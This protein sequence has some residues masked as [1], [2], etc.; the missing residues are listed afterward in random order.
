MK[1]NVLIAIML[2]SLTMLARYAYCQDLF[3]NS[4]LAGDLISKYKQLSA[5][6]LLDTANYYFDRN[7]TDTALVCYSLIINTSVK[8]ADIEQQQR[9][10]EALNRTALIYYY[11]CDY[12]SAYEFLIRALLLC[13]KYNYI[14]YKPRIYTNIGIIYSR[15]NK[16]NMA[17]PY[18]LKA[19]SLC[20]DSTSIAAIL[21]NLGGIELKSGKLDSALYFLNKSLQISKRHNDTYLHNI[22]NTIGWL[23]QEIKHY[24]SAYYYFRLSLNEAKKN[25]KVE[26]EAENLSSLA[27]LFFETNKTDSALLYIDLSNIIAERNNFLSILAENY[28]T[29]SKIED[30]KG[31]NKNAFEY[32]KTYANLRDSVFNIRNFGEI[33]Q[34]QRLYEV[35]KTNQEIEQLVMEQQIKERTIIYQRTIQFIT[36]IVLLLVIFILLAMFFQKRKLNTAYKVL[37][38]KNLKI[39]DLQEKSSEKYKKSALTHD[40]QGALLDKILILMQDTSIICDTKFSIDKLA[41]LAQSNQKYVSQVINDTFKKNFR[42]FLNGYRIREAQQLFSAPDATKYTIEAVAFRVGF[43][44]QSAFRDAF[45]EVTGV[46]PNFYLKSM[47]EQNNS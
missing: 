6:Q 27:K 7:S 19:L 20:S 35:S 44:S 1:K 36:L 30:A 21:N 45:K 37:F 46:S 24:D 42:S 15:F 31:H 29:L 32:F 38:E 47:Q 18:L 40:L 23:Y 3:F 41:E 11:M 43:K 12:R 26:V 8:D 34:L 14:P 39:I 9:I 13:E 22:Q 10:V 17:K 28:L 16:Y 25:N 5:Q 4:S 33:N 2:L